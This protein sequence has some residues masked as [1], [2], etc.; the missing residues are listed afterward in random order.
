MKNLM[1]IS[2]MI[3]LVAA[4]GCGDNKMEEQAAPAADPT[5]EHH[6]AAPAADDNVWRGT[7]AETMDAAT[8]TYVLLDMDG[9]QQWVAGPQTEVAVGDKVMMQAGMAMADFTSQAL[10][11]TFDVVYFVGGIEHDDGHGH[12]PSDGMPT[13]GADFGAST[14]EA[15]SHMTLENASVQGVEKAAGGQTVAEVHNKAVELSGKTVKI[16]ARVVKFSANIMGTNWVHIQDGSGTEGTHDLTITTDAVVQVGDMVIV[17]GPLSVDRDFGA[18]YRYGV[19]VE[20][21]SVT[22]E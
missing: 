13:M 7:V 12:A 6:A 20:K 11:R 4:A 10:E 16:R 3:L 19:I 17:E 14:G 9:Q 21:A 5:T 1:L 2:A 18:G 15:K 8:Y 22:K